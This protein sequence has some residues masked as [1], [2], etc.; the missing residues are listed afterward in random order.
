M[1]EALLKAGFEPMVMSAAENE[2]GLDDAAAKWGK[3]I[4]DNHIHAGE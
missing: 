2:R 4:R 1:H 3:V